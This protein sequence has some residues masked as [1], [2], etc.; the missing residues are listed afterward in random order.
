MK[1]CSRHGHQQSAERNYKRK[2]TLS[3]IK[4]Q[5]L[6]KLDKKEKKKIMNES[7]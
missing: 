7:V 2:N 5:E 4:G 3:Q 6:R 1:E